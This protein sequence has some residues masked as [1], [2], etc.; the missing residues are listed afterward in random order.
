MTS[1]NYK[2]PAFL[3]Y[4]TDF[5]VGTAF[6]TNEEVGMYIRILCNIADKGSLTEYQ[7]EL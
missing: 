6:M 4:Y 5:L 1:F 2:D 7:M 3:L